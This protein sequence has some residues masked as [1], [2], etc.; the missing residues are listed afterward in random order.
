MAEPT[1]AE[2]LARL[3]TI[4]AEREALEA[5]EAEEREALDLKARRLLDDE[6]VAPSWRAVGLG[7]VSLCGAESTEV[8]V[9]DADAYTRWAAEARPELVTIVARVPW[10]PLAAT[11]IDTE[12]KA[13]LAKLRSAGA[14]VATEVDPALLKALASAGVAEGGRLF[15][16]DGEV[17]GVAVVPRRPYLQ[18]KLMPEARARARAALERLA[19][20]ERERSEPVG[21]GAGAIDDPVEVQAAADHRLA[22]AQADHWG[23]GE[24][25]GAL[26]PLE[27]DQVEQVDEEVAARIAGY[28]AEVAKGRRQIAELRET[29]ERLGVRVP[30][31]EAP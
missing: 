21:E 1:I 7:T 8:V 10:A 3:L 25:A 6:G 26:D 13:A 28:Q 20:V 9:R 18:V 4:R 5:V 30:P 11:G 29:A 12:V 27:D 14:E 17:T 31:V 24:G 23:G 22:Q 2:R 15:T 16:E 19:E